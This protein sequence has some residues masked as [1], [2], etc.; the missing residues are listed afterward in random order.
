MAEP[1]LSSSHSRAA[2]GKAD[3]G[4]VSSSQDPTGWDFGSGFRLAC[5]LQLLTAVKPQLVEG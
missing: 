4:A 5:W 1:R 2:A 3:A